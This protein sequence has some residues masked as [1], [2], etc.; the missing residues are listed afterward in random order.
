MH[1]DRDILNRF[2]D[3]ELAPE[4]MVQVA[5]QITV[6][7]KW[8]AYLR[9]QENLKAMLAA[10]F[11]EV[12][13]PLPQR[14]IDAA[15]KTP[16]SPWWIAR[17]RLREILVLRGL[18]PMGGLLA[19]GLVMLWF[20]GSRGTLMEDASGH[21]IAAGR[22]ADALNTQLASAKDPSAANQIGISF[23]DTTG[24]DCRTFTSGSNAGLACRQDGAWRIKI[25][26]ATTREDTGAVYQMA[27]TAM[28]QAVR[29]E[30]R[31]IIAGSA[32]DAAAERAARDRHWS[33]Q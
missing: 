30:V 31:A 2:M 5:R 27:G 21:M 8:D 33:G 6:E 23:R 26:A 19:A 28:P 18:A 29:D 25:L 10:R 13:T 9:A 14:L 11:R 12:E 20:A 1:L 16:I 22:L 32:F 3:G 15:E 4:E 7:P 24:R 17:M